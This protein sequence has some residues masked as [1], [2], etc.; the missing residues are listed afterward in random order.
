MFILPATPLA[1]SSPALYAI[2]MSWIILNPTSELLFLFAYS[3]KTRSFLLSLLGLGLLFHLSKASWTPLFAEIGALIFGYLFT[4]IAC[5]THS[6]FR[7][8]IGLEKGVLRLI[9][10]FNFRK[11]K[12]PKHTKIY[13][14]Q[15]GEPILSDEDFMDAMLARISLYGESTLTAQEKLRMQQISEKTKR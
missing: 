14:I 8:L 15:S 3:F 13:D 1:G 10:L 2:L 7:L 4:V 9:E 5:K 11:H 12:T 6:P